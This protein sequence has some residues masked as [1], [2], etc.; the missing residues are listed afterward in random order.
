[1]THIVETS[2]DQK[3]HVLYV[4]SWL[5]AEQLLFLKLNDYLLVYQLRFE[6]LKMRFV[7][8][9]SL[10]LLLSH[11]FIEFPLVFLTDLYL[12]RFW[13]LLRFFVLLLFDP[14]SLL[15]LFS[16]FLSK[17]SDQFCLSSLLQLLLLSLFL[18]G[19]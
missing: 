17:L 7:G 4:L 19:L 3:I 11:Q 16:L 10:F 5:D 2:S 6:T 14:L 15:F 13:S 12:I 1:M 18:F 9:L 8:K